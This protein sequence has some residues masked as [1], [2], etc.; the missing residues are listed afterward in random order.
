MNKKESLSGKTPRCTELPKVTDPETAKGTLRAVS[1]TSHDLLTPVGSYTRGAQSDALRDLRRERDRLIEEL[2]HQE[3]VEQDHP[4]TGNHMADDATEVSEQ[5]KTLALRRHLEGM[6][7]EID[8]AIARAQKGMY[9]V[10]E[11]CGKSIS[12]E[13]LSVMHSASLCIDCARLLTKNPK[14][15]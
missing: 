6:L 9:G 2:R 10:C 15:A 14:V 12:D 13:R 3:V 5:A 4:T 11:Q 8:H 1:L 7:Q